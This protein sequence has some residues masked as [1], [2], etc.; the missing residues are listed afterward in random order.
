MDSQINRLF[1]SFQDEINQ[2]IDF[3]S[4]E[5]VFLTYL[6]KKGKLNEQFTL[7][8]TLPKQ[9]ISLYGQKLNVMKSKLEQIL[10]EK[11]AEILNKKDNDWIDLTLPASDVLGNTH[12]ITKTISKIRSIFTPL[13]FVQMSYNEVEWEYFAFEALNI[14]SSHPARDDVETFFVD[15]PPSNQWGKMVLTPHTSSGQVREMKRLKSTPPIKMIN[16]SK[17]YRPN[18][19]ATHVPV[20]HQFEGLTIDTDIS[21]PHL[22]GTIQHFVTNFFGEGTTIR[23]RPYNFRFTEPSFEVDISCKNCM[24]KGAVNGVKCRVCKYGWLELGG[25]GMV[26]PNVLK[27]GGIDPN[28]FSGWAFGFGIE[29][30]AMMKGNLKLPDL[31]MFYSNDIDLLRQF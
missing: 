7:L 27:A 4:W 23:L 11:K 13:G 8:K 16:I 26:H 28:I 6:G 3:K 14:P 31:R 24:G 20:F 5:Q 29:R 22:K 10:T 21:I 1:E 9:D 19:D 15:T 2:V 12:L 25:A 18:W 30:V 17:C